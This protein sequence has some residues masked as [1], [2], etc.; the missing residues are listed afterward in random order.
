MKCI[1]LGYYSSPG[2]HRLGRSIDPS[3]Y[4][5][6]QTAHVAIAMESDPFLIHGGMGFSRHTSGWDSSY[7]G[8]PLPF[9]HLIP[10]HSLSSFI[11]CYLS[12]PASTCPPNN[13]SMT[14]CSSSMGCSHNSLLLPRHHCLLNHPSSVLS[15][16]VC[17]L[18]NLQVEGQ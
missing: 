2:H 18:H 16:N 17:L 9:F 12:W 4:L 5:C 14:T 1:T 15:D 11:D 8:M 13:S 6:P 7:N 3:A 10:L